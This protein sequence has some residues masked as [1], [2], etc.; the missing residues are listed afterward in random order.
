MVAHPII[1]AG[2]MEINC[3]CYHR[4]SMHY[5]SRSNG[6][7]CGGNRGSSRRYYASAYGNIVVV[8]I[9]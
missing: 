1:I 4:I 3:G 6:N 2:R 8:F 5:C 7:Y 9:N